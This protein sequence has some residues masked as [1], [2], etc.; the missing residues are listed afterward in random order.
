L[1]LFQNND[2]TTKDFIIIAEFSELEGPIPLC[3]IPPNA[4]D[5]TDIKLN[6]FSVHLMSTDYQVNTMYGDLKS[7]RYF[8]F[9][10][11]VWLWFFM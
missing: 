1:C 2:D 7:M 3:T 6:A 11:S 4:A 8:G 5:K 10:E 9:G